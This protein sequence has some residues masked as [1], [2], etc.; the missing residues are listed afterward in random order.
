[1][2]SC[3]ITSYGLP[4]HTQ[5]RP[6]PRLKNHLTC[7]RTSARTGLVERNTVNCR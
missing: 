5:M 3:R 7:R 1:M 2:A 6:V 4:L